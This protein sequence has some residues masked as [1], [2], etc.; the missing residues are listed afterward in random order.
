M[1]KRTGIRQ[2]EDSGRSFAVSIRKHRVSRAGRILRSVGEWW[3]EPG[4][5]IDQSIMGGNEGN[6]ESDQ[7]Q[8][9]DAGWIPAFHKT[10]VGSGNP[11]ENRTKRRAIR[12]FAKRLAPGASASFIRCNSVAPRDP[13]AEEMEQRGNC[14]T[15][16]KSPD[17]QYQDV[18][19]SAIR[20]ASIC[21]QQGTPTRRRLLEVSPSSESS[22][23]GKKKAGQSHS[24]TAL[25]EPS[26]F[27]KRLH[28]S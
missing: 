18:L 23:S 20:A 25:D 4:H 19:S 28:R 21:E 13:V 8:F 9:K 27:H 15:M 5:R 22:C 1:G 6:G 11:K 24:A 16:P 14:E 7:E 17:L 2:E 12:R 10:F 3:R 26:S